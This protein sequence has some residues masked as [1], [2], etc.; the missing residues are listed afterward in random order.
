MRSKDVD[1]LLLLAALWGGSFL[2]MRIAAPVIG[3]VVLAELRVGIAGG[4][5]LV[6]V[7]AIRSVPA[8]RAQGKCCRLTASGNM[9]RY[10]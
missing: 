9:L 8:F 10:Q 2:F 3:S 6:Y 7:A 4:A 5:P 1:A